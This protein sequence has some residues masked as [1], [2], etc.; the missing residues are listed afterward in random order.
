MG[1]TEVG[2]V[3][4]GEILFTFKFFY[5][6]KAHLIAPRVAFVEIKTSYFVYNITINCV[7]FFLNDR[8][9]TV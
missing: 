4:L 5:T 8:H 3:I 1:H 9:T 6:E 2:F 7:D